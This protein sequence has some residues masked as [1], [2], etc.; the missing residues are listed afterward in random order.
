MSELNWKYEAQK[1]AVNAGELRIAIAEQLED[2]RTQ[3]LAIHKQLLFE[4]NDFD[5]VILT[6]KKE[7]LENQERWLKDVLVGK[8]CASSG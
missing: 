3:I 4:D 5:I 7:Q 6:W 1:Q 8:R 2:V